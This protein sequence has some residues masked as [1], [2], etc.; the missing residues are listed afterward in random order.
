MEKVIG[1]RGAAV[2]PTENYI[3]C[4]VRAPDGKFGDLGDGKS[5]SIGNRGA[6]VAPTERLIFC[7]D[8][9]PDGKFE[10][11]GGGGSYR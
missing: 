7:M 4:G 2:V 3:F 1:N 11:I 6:A 5:Y 10:D 8:R 9:S